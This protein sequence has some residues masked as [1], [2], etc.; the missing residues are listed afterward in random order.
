MGFAMS[1]ARGIEQNNPTFYGKCPQVRQGPLVH[2]N[3]VILIR[4]S[5]T[6]GG[7]NVIRERLQQTQRCFSR[8]YPIWQF[9]RNRIS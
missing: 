6:P 9:R 5:F 1:S 8:R 2:G 3:D 7:D 4:R